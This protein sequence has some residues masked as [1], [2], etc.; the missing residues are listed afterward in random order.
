MKLEK[1]MIFAFLLTNFVNVHILH[2]NMEDPPVGTFM[3][4]I[5]FQLP[6]ELSKNESEKYH[7]YHFIQVFVNGLGPFALGFN[8]P[9]S[10]VSFLDYFMTKILMGIDI[11]H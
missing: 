6:I 1:K 3:E 8:S 7:V 2:I 9:K 4:K 5:Q 10:F 11:E